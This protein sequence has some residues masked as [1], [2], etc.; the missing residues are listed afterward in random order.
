[1]ADTKPPMSPALEAANIKKAEAEAEHALA[2]ARLAT[3]QALEA[4]AEAEI[5]AHRLA[6]AREEERG[7][8]QSDEHHRVYQFSTDVSSASAA[9]CM[10]T[11]RRWHRLDPTC[12]IEIVFNSPGGSVIAGMG[13][14]DQIKRLS[15][16]GGGSHRV[17]TGICGY[18]ASMAGI[19]LQ[20]GDH[21]WMGAE[22]Y[23]MIH[24]ISAG[25][26]GK[27]GEIKDDVK[28]YEAI[29]A[30][31]VGIFVDRSG[32]KIT[33]ARFQKAWQ[34]TDWWLLSDEALKLGFV[35]EVR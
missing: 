23:L 21:R 27:I 22:S 11:L 9:A 5:T 10:S 3:A 16:R 24:E 26:G 31:V 1:M 20:A 33:K 2:Q 15:L 18:A 28:F 8:V 7:R 6:K 30:R 29:C 14:F 34:R 35:D 17:T 12:D 32:G 25:T 19:L 4:E 13:L